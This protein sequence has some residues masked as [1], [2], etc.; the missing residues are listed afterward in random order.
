MNIRNWPLDRIMQLPDSCFGRRFSVCA[1][2]STDDST[3]AWDISEIAFPETFVLWEVAI[4]QHYFGF[5]EFFDSLRLALGDQLPTA[6][7]MMNAL[8]PLIPGFGAQGPEPRYFMALP[9]YFAFHMRNPI[10][11]KGRRLVLEATPLPEVN[12]DVQVVCEVSSMPTEV[13]DWLC[14]V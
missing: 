10:S 1:H 8:E 12:I 5:T 7:A 13:P 9:D 14:S 3:V 6:A 4:S 2:V 11:A